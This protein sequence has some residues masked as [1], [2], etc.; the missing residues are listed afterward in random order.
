MCIRDSSHGHG[1]MRV[2]MD[3]TGLA[4]FLRSRGSWNDDDVRVTFRPIALEVVAGA[5]ADDAAAVRADAEQ[6]E[7][8]ED[9]PIT[10][11][12]V[13]VQMR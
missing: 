2:A 3:I 13:S 11:G 12:R 1:G 6:S 9:V 4:E 8:H 7:Q 5:A 10:V